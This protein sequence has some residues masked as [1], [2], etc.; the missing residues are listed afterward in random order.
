[1]PA[2]LCLRRLRFGGSFVLCPFSFAVLPALIA[3][4]FTTVIARAD[5]ALLDR[6]FASQAKIDSW[7]AAF[8]QTRT[9]KALK[10]PLRA[11]GR[12]WFAAPNR[13]RWELG[14]PP[15]TIAVREASQMVIV[16]PRLRRAEKYSLTDEAA[17]QWR[18]ALTL[19]ETGMPRDRAT[20]EERFRQESFTVQ[21]QTAV[22]VL[23][24]RSAQARRMIAGV[25]VEFHVESLMLTATELR[26]A[27]GSTLRNDFRDV[28]VNPALD[29]G[30]FQAP[31]GEGYEVREPLS[32]NRR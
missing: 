24:P 28:E 12:V 6:W 3:L 32:G 25:R 2:R 4:L 5:D 11:D 21:E 17:G 9:L 1:M 16:Y 26:F 7:T 13:F 23:K 29:D 8:T 10:E 22:L 19:I 20:L 27:D 18:D 14:D 30:R 31:I 15:Q